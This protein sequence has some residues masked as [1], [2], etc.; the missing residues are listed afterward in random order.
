[1]YELVKM[2]EDW[3]HHEN[4]TIK[5]VQPLSHQGESAVPLQRKEGYDR[6]VAPLGTMLQDG[7]WA[8]LESLGGP[9]WEHSQPSRN[10]IKQGHTLT[11]C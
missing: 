11:Q 1:M 7:T 9:C 5:E 3:N 2:S 10:Q 8:I 4:K 6:N